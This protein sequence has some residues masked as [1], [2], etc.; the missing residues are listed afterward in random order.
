[1]YQYEFGSPSNLFVLLVSKLKGKTKGTIS[2]SYCVDIPLRYESWNQ[3]KRTSTSIVDDVFKDTR[4][5]LAIFKD[6][7]FVAKM[8]DGVSETGQNFCLSW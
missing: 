4:G 8:R 1:M 3:K 7:V 2:N 5:V 6:S